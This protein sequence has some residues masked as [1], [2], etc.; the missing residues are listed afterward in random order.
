MSGVNYEVIYFSFQFP[1]PV[2]IV[3]VIKLVKSLSYIF[4]F[5]R[6]REN[7][8]NLENYVLFACVYLMKIRTNHVEIIIH[9]VQYSLIY[10]K[11]LWKMTLCWKKQNFKEPQEKK[12]KKRKIQT[13]LQNANKKCKDTDPPNK[14]YIHVW[15]SWRLFFLFLQFLMLSQSR[16]RTH[17]FTILRHWSW[18]R[19]EPHKLLIIPELNGAKKFAETAASREEGTWGKKSRAAAPI[20]IFCCQDHAGSSLTLSAWGL[21]DGLRRRSG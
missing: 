9:V 5:K 4:A 16:H 11:T 8:Y 12:K 21:L 2:H 15:E 20:R 17:S 7:N 19:S 14:F 1:W 18:L 10:C 13:T 6:E 3:E